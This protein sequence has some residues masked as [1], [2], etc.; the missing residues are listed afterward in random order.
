MIARLKHFFK[1]SVIGGLTVILPVVILLA[2]FSWLFNFITG[3]LQPMTDLIVAHSRVKE[4][5]AHFLGLLIIVILCFV[6]G[7]VVRTGL[8]RLAH[9]L[10]E[11]KFLRIAPGYN[12][13]KETVSQFL[14][15]KEHFFSKVALV[16]LGG[17][18]VLMTAF[19]TAEHPDGIYTV[20]IPTS[21]NPTSGLIFHLPASSVFLVSVSVEDAMRSIISCGT[22]SIPLI[23]SFLKA[24][25]NT[26]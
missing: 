26:L 4:L 22:S 25:K 15:S 13:I 6:V 20:F 24:R 18:E 8:G 10:I 3:L 11:E 23:D 12:L 17:S 2:V 21:P 5:L 1:T 16:K 19:V 14:G 9:S 7:I